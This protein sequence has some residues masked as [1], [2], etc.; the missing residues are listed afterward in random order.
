MK[1]AFAFDPPVQHKYEGRGHILDQNIGRDRVAAPLPPRK[2]A[3][4]IIG[5]PFRNFLPKMFMNEGSS[6]GAHRRVGVLAMLMNVLEDWKAEADH[7]F[8]GL[9]GGGWVFSL[10]RS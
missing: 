2:A 1:R 5:N 6:L 8:V 9:A 10:N 7:S 3:L 4:Q